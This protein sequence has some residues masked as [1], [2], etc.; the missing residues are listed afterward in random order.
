MI[1]LKNEK[2]NKVVNI[3]EKSP[4]FIY[5]SFIL[6]IVS[7]ILFI[8]EKGSIP[9]KVSSLLLIVGSIKSKED[10]N[11]NEFYKIPLIMFIIEILMIIFLF[12]IFILDSSLHFLTLDSLLVIVFIWAIIITL[13][14]LIRVVSTGYNVFNGRKKEIR[15]YLNNGFIVIN[16]NELNK[17]ELKLINK[18]NKKW[19]IK[20]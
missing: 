10:G 4:M 12:I 13:L 16:M 3:E 5:Y 7:I 11:F 8:V 19:N 18:V 17:K 1:K 9:L 6:F 14:L 20:I 2:E 15:K